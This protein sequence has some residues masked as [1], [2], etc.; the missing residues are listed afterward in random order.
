MTG[1]PPRDEAAARPGRDPWE[2]VVTATRDGL[3]ESNYLKANSPDGRRGFW[4]KHNVLRGRHASRAEFWVVLFERGRPPLVA[5]RDVD[6]A[7]VSLD[8]E[9]I[10]I[11]GPGIALHPGRAVGEIAGLRWNLAMSGGLPPLHHLPHD[12]MYRAGFP[13]KKILTPAPNLVFDGA[14]EAGGRAW[15]VEGWRGLR[16]HNWGTEHAHAYA[17]GNCNLWDDGDPRRT[18]DGFTA[19]IRLGP[20]RSPWLSALLV[21]RP[22]RDRTGIGRWLGAGAVEPGE[23][24]DPGEAL[25]WTVGWKGVRLAMR[26]PPS[27]FAGLRYAHPDG[28]ESCC[29][30]TKFAE[31]RLEVD[32]AGGPWT[33]RAGELEILLPGPLP[34]L[35]L[36]PDPDWDPA[37]GPY[38]SAEPAAWLAG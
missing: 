16:G 13:K 11:E 18:V 28:R 34:G 23:P 20:L 25:R 19:R 21:R 10:R 31:V 12:W 30:N 26:A 24:R 3:Y 14:F 22:D 6:L 32:G 2:R 29:Y 36:H 27:A 33:S 17:Y 7:G 15:R 4:I 38:R 9:R 37:A 35:P 5:R 1:H 8:A